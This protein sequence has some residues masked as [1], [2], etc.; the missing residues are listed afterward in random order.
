[1][2]DALAQVGVDVTEGWPVGIDPGQS[3][4]SFGFQVGLFFAFSQPGQEQFAP[5]PAVIEQERQRMAARAAWSDYFADV[6][7]FVCPVNFTTA[8]PHD[9]RPFEDR[10]ILTADGERSYTDQPFWI[11]HASLAGLPAVAAS[12]GRTSGGLP[13]GAQIIGPLHED[14]TAITFAELLAEVTGGFQ[15]PRV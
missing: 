3:A 4:E 6:D 7:V 5:L 8:F 11:A 13:V 15:Q 2:V 10:T 14:D 9:P 1:M 12:A